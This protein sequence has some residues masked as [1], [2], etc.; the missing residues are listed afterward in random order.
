MSDAPDAAAAALVPVSAPSPPPPAAAGAAAP[1]LM[2]K[3]SRLLMTVTDFYK[4][5]NPATLS[6]AIDI[7]CVEHQDG[8]LT[9]SPFHVRFGKLQLLR[10]HE[11]IVEIKVND[12]PVD[13]HMKV[14]EA[15]EAFFVIETDSPVPE[16]ATSPIA[17]PTAHPAGDVEPLDLGAS[18]APSIAANDEANQD[19]DTPQ[20]A[21]LTTSITS[22]AGSDDGHAAPHEPAEPT[23]DAPVPEEETAAADADDEDVAGDANAEAEDGAAPPSTLVAEN[24]YHSAS[25]YS[26]HDSDHHDHDDDAPSAPDANGEDASG[27]PIVVDDAQ[28]EQN[29]SAVVVAVPDAAADETAVI[30]DEVDHV[31]IDVATPTTNDQDGPHPF[32]D[33]EAEIEAR[34]GSKLKPI[35]PLSDTELEYHELP[36]SAAAAA[37]ATGASKWSWGW[38]KMPVKGGSGEST[39]GD[40]IMTAPVGM[41]AGPGSVVSTTRALVPQGDDR[42]VPIDLSLCGYR[43]DLTDGEFLAKRVSYD[44]FSS[45]PTLLTSRD[46]VVK[47]DGRF[48]PWSVA[49]PVLLSQLVF[50]TPLPDTAVQ[51][52]LAQAAPAPPK[53]SSWRWWSRGA[54]S[55]GAAPDAPAAPRAIA[56]PRLAADAR[57]HS[58]M[59]PDP[60]VPAP[61]PPVRAQSVDEIKVPVPADV[62]LPS[63][64]V[65]TPAADTS[66]S[67][68]ADHRHYMKTLRLTSD[69]L[70]SLGLQRGANQVTFTVVSSLQGRAE[71]HAR[72]FLWD[73]TEKI[74]ISDID[75]TITKSDALGHLFTMVGRDWTHS[76]VAS[77]YTGVR[78]NGYQ[79]LYLTSRAIGQAQYTR[80]YLNKVEQGAFQLPDGPVF[81]SPDRLVAAFTREVIQRRPEEFKVACLRDIRSLF[82]PDTN[83]PF[84]AGFGNRSTD[85]FSYRAVGVPVSRIFTINPTGEVRRELLE[86][87]K[88]TYVALG[89]LVDQIF[90]PVRAAARDV[91]AEF[92]DWSY[93]RQ[94]LPSV[95]I[96]LPEDEEGGAGG[97]EAE[98]AGEGVEEGDDEEMEEGDDEDEEY[99]EYDAEDEDEADDDDAQLAQQ[100]REMVVHPYL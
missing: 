81:L 53:R 100:M 70:K 22:N 47:L 65:A 94:A 61:E 68:D 41:G 37:A 42:A 5:I 39:A 78:K 21:T 35:A 15:G 50:H 20:P 72:I 32:S 63:S 56:P 73:W 93:W 77:L 49:A 45:H 91:Q 54:R 8:S 48:L 82:A 88:A 25:E 75:G 90:P 18:A 79:L 7:V 96:D 40:S 26:D 6:G 29:G 98:A 74:V 4:D 71:C 1:G 23:L 14:G 30:A 16:L 9:A 57:S 89:G 11:K 76:G 43:Q 84:Y 24:G 10:P 31:A 60:I 69:Q 12:Q 58:D 46:L 83:T 44:Q 28:V 38:G 80:N 19:V 33:T 27:E 51:N 99:D 97:E 92:N 64:P 55:S 34:Y 67:A 3:V 86:G 52:L 66:A 2:A 17:H 36:S 87:Y 13:L 59:P 85:A 62:Q 95:T